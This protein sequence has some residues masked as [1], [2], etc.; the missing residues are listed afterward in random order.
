MALKVNKDLLPL[1]IHYFFKYGGI[2]FFFLL[3]VVA[4]QKGIP[5]LAVGLMWSVTPL[6]SCAIN[7]LMSTLADAFKIHRALFLAGM[8]VFSCS[9]ITIFLLPDVSK[10]LS[11]ETAATVSLQCLD[12]NTRLSVCSSD[13]RYSSN[14][15]TLP[16]FQKCVNDDAVDQ[17]T[18]TEEYEINC[19]IQCTYRHNEGLSFVNFSENFRLPTDLIM[20][21]GSEQSLYDACEESQCTIITETDA[22]PALS[23]SLNFTCG[24]NYDAMCTY[25]YGVPGSK[26]EEDITLIDVVKTG[27]FWLMFI[28]LLLVYGG[29][30]TTTTIADTVCFTLLGTARHKYGRQ[31]MWGSLGW[32]CVGTVSGAL[33]DYFTKGESQTNYT[34]ALIISIIFLT[35]NLFVSLKIPFNISKREKLKASSVGN[36]ICTFKMMIYLM[37]VAVGGSTVGMIWTFLFI[38]VEDVAT[39]WDPNFA[40]IKLLQGLMVGTSCFL[41]EVPFLFLSS[42]I[43]KRIGNI[44]TFT[45]SLT[46]FSIRVLLYSFVTNPWF[47]LPVDLLNGVSFG[48]FYPNMISYGSLMSP[49]GAQATVQSIVKSVFIGGVS[50]GALLGG[51]LIEAVGGPMTYFYL[52]LFDVA[53]TLFFIIAQFFIYRQ[54][55]KYPKDETTESTVPE[56]HKMLDGTEQMPFDCDAVEQRSIC[57][58][59]T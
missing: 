58:L 7:L 56:D 24:M 29:N 11:V 52:G 40:H 20:N 21:V 35:I 43:I 53:F 42:Y 51:L 1:K 54:D 39:A 36:A 26:L 34:P 33:V 28:L 8:V 6:T 13:H 38:M 14:T 2:A 12:N 4:Q 44:I 57:D 25:H 5:T 3:P 55:S 41:A 59:P 31:R 48:L 10:S 45:I 18:K 19:K 32:G 22:T 23:Q 50:L 17:M 16:A 46:A 15:S 9:F 37:T 49:K 47:F 27:E 30:A